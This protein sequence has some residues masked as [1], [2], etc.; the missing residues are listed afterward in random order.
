VIQITADPANPERLL[1][2]SLTSLYL[3]KVA[4]AALSDEIERAVRQQAISDLQSNPAVRALITKASTELLLKLLS[5]G[6]PVTGPNLIPTS[7]GS[8]ASKETL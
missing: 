5:A 8:S 4:L 7:N 6:V 2:N 1:I 3:D